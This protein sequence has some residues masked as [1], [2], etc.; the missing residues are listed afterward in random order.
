MKI[1]PNIVLALLFTIIV[2]GLAIGEHYRP[3]P[4]NYIS[5]QQT[6]YWEVDDKGHIWGTMKIND[7]H[8]VVDAESFTALK[9][10]AKSIAKD[11][12]DVDIKSFTF[13]PISA[14]DKKCPFKL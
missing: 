5:M 9:E 10:R 12:E 1:P 4:Q 8:I 6:L 13:A 11:I 7:N 2:G 14:M 3:K